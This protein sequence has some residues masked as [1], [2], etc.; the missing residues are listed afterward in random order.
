MAEPHL[1]LFAAAGPAENV[2]AELG[3]VAAEARTVA[4]NGTQQ[5]DLYGLHLA[6]KCVGDWP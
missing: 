6:L 4:G 1:C 2:R 5:E 3:H